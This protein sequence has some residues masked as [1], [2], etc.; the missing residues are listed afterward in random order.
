MRRTDFEPE[1]RNYL[2]VRMASVSTEIKIWALRS[3]LEMHANSS[4]STSGLLTEEEL[5]Q[6]S[7]FSASESQAAFAYRRMARKIIVASNTDLSPSKVT[8]KF[9]P[10]G[11]PR[12]ADER[13]RFSSSSSRQ[14]ILIGLAKSG[15][16]GVD[17]QHPVDQVDPEKLVYK[18]AGPQEIAEAVATW[19]DDI[20][21][22]F[23]RLWVVKEAAVKATG[24]GLAIDLRR[25]I[26]SPKPDGASIVIRSSKINCK[27]SAVFLYVWADAQ[28]CVVFNCVR[29][30]IQIF[31]ELPS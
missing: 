29:P 8:F 28:A 13:F 15:L 5:E 7:R 11:E 4:H 17:V 24:L 19:G 26:V 30:D 14:H 6:M 21:R 22:V 27:L 31:N 10:R 16:F 2:A 9:G 18:I 23:Y 25:V 1:R 20:G 3:P 12:L